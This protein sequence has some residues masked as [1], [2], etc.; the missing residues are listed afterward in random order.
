MPS[1]CIGRAEKMSKIDWRAV[2]WSKR[3]ID[4]SRELNR[5]A[6]TVSDNRAK[7]APETLK[8]HKNI[9][10]LK[11]D[12]LKTTVQIAKE[13]KVGFCIVAKARKKYAPETVIITPDWDKVD[14]TKNNRQLAQELGKSYNTVAK[15]RCQLKQSGK[16]KERTVRI[17]KGQK[18][19]Q[20]AFGVVN[21][22]LA[23]KAAK[24][25]PKAGKFETNVHAKKWRI[26]SPDNQVFIVTNLYQF[27][28]DH[29]HLFL[30]GDVIFKRTGGKRGTGGEYCNA[31]N[32]LANAS[33]T[34][35]EMWKGWKCK[36]I[37]EDKKDE[38]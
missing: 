1:V 7:Y 21:Q 32:G 37:K 25:S 20:M 31:T 10:W 35:R 2:D 28:R 17:D 23:T 22:P 36:Q 27:V 15:K 8:S 38:L 14:W 33:T 4:L 12:W 34:K 11:I 19:P 5:T 9:D 24:A 16:A 18:K 13:L 30:P 3:T 26:T 6:K 29:T